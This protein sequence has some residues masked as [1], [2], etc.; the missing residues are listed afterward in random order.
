[1]SRPLGTRGWPG[2]ARKKSSEKCIPPAQ[3]PV[4]S[5]PGRALIMGQTMNKPRPPPA[6][7]CKTTPALPSYIPPTNPGPST[8]LKDYYYYVFLLKVDTR[9]AAWSLTVHDRYTTVQNSTGYLKTSFHRVCFT[10]CPF[11]MIHWYLNPIIYWTGVKISSTSEVQTLNDHIFFCK[12]RHL[13]VGLRITEFGHRDFCIDY[14]FLVH[15][16][17]EKGGQ[18]DDR[19]APFSF[20]QCI[21]NQ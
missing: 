21:R 9:I 1:M 15:C 20:P 3:I 8:I 5:R 16:G 18:I 6:G 2:L 13:Y 19:L 11:V 4:K 17:N 14:C 10:A 12:R 7:I